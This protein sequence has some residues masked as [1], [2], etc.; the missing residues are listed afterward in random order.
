[1]TFIKTNQRWQ[2]TSEYSCKRLTPWTTSVP[3]RRTSRITNPTTCQSTYK[4]N[5]AAWPQDK[6]PL[7]ADQALYWFHANQNIQFQKNNE[8]VF[9]ELKDLFRIRFN[10]NFPNG[11]PIVPAKRTLSIIYQSASA[12]FDNIINTKLPDINYLS[13]STSTPLAIIYPLM[14][15]T[16]AEIQPFSKQLDHKNSDRS[17]LSV[18]V[19]LPLE[20]WK[21]SHNENIAK[22]QSWLDRT[23][24]NDKTPTVLEL[25]R[26]TE[27]DPDLTNVTDAKLKRAVNLLSKLAYGITPDPDYSIKK[28][29]STDPITIFKL[30][31][32]RDAP[33][34]PSELYQDVQLTAT[35]LTMLTKSEPNLIDTESPHLK[36]LR[37]TAKLDKDQRI[38]LNQNIAWAYRNNLNSQTIQ[39]HL[40]KLP[41]TNKTQMSQ[42]IVQTVISQPTSHPNTIK[43]A[44]AMLKGMGLTSTVYTLIHEYLGAQNA[45]EPK[46][47]TEPAK[48]NPRR[49]R[50]TAPTKP[51]P[52]S[53]DRPLVELDQRKIDQAITDSEQSRKLLTAVFTQP[54]DPKSTLTTEPRQPIK[55]G[56]TETQ[57]QEPVTVTELPEVKDQFPG[58]DQAHAKILHQIIDTEYIDQNQFDRMTRTARL[59]SEGA[60]ET[61]NEWSYSLFEDFLLDPET[62]GYSL[63]QDTRTKILT[64]AT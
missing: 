47:T 24:K 16:L 12:C 40:T 55:D 15:S 44:N 28:P 18:Q 35:V 19:S 63:N 49:T 23:I 64:G 57:N 53:Q 36:Q 17:L 5:W 30:S 34:L 2:T 14:K 31:T 38:R 6:L 37:K 29:V 25:V 50:R 54:D 33:A 60:V 41:N 9:P 26:R 42:L 13:Q 22:F 51:K 62:D 59:P 3:I 32:P 56:T 61:I 21:K 39:R 20:I 4:Q 48:T 11:I 7:Q 8:K 43:A 1:M 45:T 10:E 27:Q 52:E 58:L 46:Q